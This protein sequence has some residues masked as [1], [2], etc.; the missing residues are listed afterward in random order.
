MGLD[1]KE[2][3]NLKETLKRNVGFILHYIFLIIIFVIGLKAIIKSPDQITTLFLT[4][5]WCYIFFRE[6]RL[7]PILIFNN[8]EGETFQY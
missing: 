1:M 8:E 4:L 5:G 6:L 3:F 7:S 2:K